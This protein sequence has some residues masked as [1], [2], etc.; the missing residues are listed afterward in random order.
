MKP[1][2]QV[3]PSGVADSGDPDVLETCVVVLVVL[4]LEPD[5][6]LD[7]LH[8][9]GNTKHRRTATTRPWRRLRR[10]IDMNCPSVTVR[11]IPAPTPT[12]IVDAANE[13]KRPHHLAPRPP[14]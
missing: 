5:D 11:G 1:G 2:I 4:V 14:W 6:L 9:A 8:A 3:T 12:R 13:E 10:L 7:E